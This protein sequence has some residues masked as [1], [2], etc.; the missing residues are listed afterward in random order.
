MTTLSEPS[1]TEWEEA[2]SVLRR[3][4][5]SRCQADLDQFEPYEPAQKLLRTPVWQRGGKYPRILADKWVP[6]A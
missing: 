6:H 3:N 1:A 4:Q 5:D 2:R